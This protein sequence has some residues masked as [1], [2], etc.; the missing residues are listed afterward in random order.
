MRTVLITGCSRGLGYELTKVYLEAQW[1]VIGISRQNIVPLL[2]SEGPHTERFHT[3]I[4]DVSTDQLSPT[5]HATLSRLDLPLDLIINNAGIPGKAH[6]LSEVTI[7]ELHALIEVHCIGALR[8]TQ[9]ALPWLLKAAKPHIANIT[10]R[11]G[12]LHK[13]AS[14][15]FAGRNFSYSYRIAKAAQNMFSICFAE[16]FNNR[17]G[18]TCLHPGLFHSA[19]AATDACLSASET[20]NRIYEYLNAHAGES[21]KYIEPPDSELPW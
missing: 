15:D 11:L 19:S 1:H 4:A 16:E 7:A 18:V 3:V 12:S 13:N 5:L 2:A 6:K 9:T 14:G 8:I 10:S 20:A 21:L 17:I